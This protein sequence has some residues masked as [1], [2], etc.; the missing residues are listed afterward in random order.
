M[1]PS[2]FPDAR[3]RL[4]L[5]AA[6]AP[7]PQAVEAWGRW[8]EGFRPDLLAFD[9][10]RLLPLVSH[11][12]KPSQPEG[13]DLLARMFR[14]SWSSGR[15]L[16]GR[17][18]EVLVGFNELGIEP[19]FSKGMALVEGCYGEAALRP[20]NDLDLLVEAGDF[21]TVLAN[22]ERLGLAA[23][24]EQTHAWSCVHRTGAK[25]DLHRYALK[26]NR[27]PDA[28]AGLWSRSRPVAVGAGRARVPAAED[29]LLIVCIHG[30]RTSSSPWIADAAWLLKQ[31]LDWKLVVEETR[32]RRAVLAVADALG[33]LHEF[34]LPVSGQA[35][36]GLRDLKVP[37]LERW[38]YRA[39][40]RKVRFSGLLFD[41]LC[42]VRAGLSRELSVF[43]RDRLRRLARSV[44][45]ETRRPPPG[46]P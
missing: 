9:E 4:L 3:R 6:L 46:R 21:A 35:L 10:Q 22:L 26:E 1:V 15:I 25:V 19:L 24:S 42:L 27:W 28:D 18:E 12:L 8:F 33:Y 11:N 17:C 23:E 7:G 40:L 29:L 39:R 20:M 41:L 45:S 37:L 5:Q 2:G 32:A 31:P 16:R 38:L 44:S 14:H 13:S 36:Q 34:G 30:V 43:L